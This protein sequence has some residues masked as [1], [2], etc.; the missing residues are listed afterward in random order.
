MVAASFRQIQEGRYYNRDDDVSLPTG[1]RLIL[2][3]NAVRL[4]GA[5]NPE[6]RQARPDVGAML[7]AFADSY[8]GLLTVLHEAF[9]GRRSR[10]ELAVPLMQRL[11]EQLVELDERRSKLAYILVLGLPVQDYAPRW[12]WQAMTH[13]N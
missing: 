2:D 1:R 12:R 11:I 6:I 3:W 13:A 8:N 4:V 5:A 10:L 9:N 7:D